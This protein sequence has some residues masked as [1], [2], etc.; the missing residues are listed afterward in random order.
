VAQLSASFSFALLLAAL[1]IYGVTAYGVAQR[2]SEIAIRLA[3]GAKPSGIVRTVLR[4]VWVLVTVGAV[5][6]TGLRLLGGDVSS[7]A[8]LRVGPARSRKPDRRSRCVGWSRRAGRLAAGV[9]RIE[10]RSS[11]PPPPEL[12]RPKDRAGRRSAAPNAARS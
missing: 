6:G 8:V 12:G 9:A 2:R 1:G 11:R 7:L 3:L 10:D 5:I 4:R